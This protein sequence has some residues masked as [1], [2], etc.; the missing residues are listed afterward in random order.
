MN[1]SFFIFYFFFDLPTRF[2]EKKIRKPINKKKMPQYHERMYNIF[3]LFCSN[4][5]QSDTC[6]KE[7]QNSPIGW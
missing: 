3:I 7:T 6:R 1:L 2:F 5:F 4:A